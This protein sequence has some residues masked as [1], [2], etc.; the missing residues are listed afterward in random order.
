M[1]A[2]EW[3]DRLKQAR[4]WE[5]DYR[6]AKE[7]EVAGSTLSR[8]RNKPES[9][10]D[11]DTAVRVAEALELEP[12]IVVLDQLAERTRSEPA[13]AALTGLLQRLTKARKDGIN[14]TSVAAAAV[15]SL[16]AL[17]GHPPTAAAPVTPDSSGISIVSV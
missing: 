9:T 16:S 2:A 5:S 10:M 3:I 15:V 12:E 6:V 7:L 17:G 1:K 11:D 8:Y 13:K 14:I 4:G